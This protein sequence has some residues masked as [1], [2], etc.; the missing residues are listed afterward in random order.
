MGK[1]LKALK[2]AI[3]SIVLIAIC[4]SGCV[5]IPD[6]VQ[7]TVCAVQGT[8]DGVD[9]VYCRDVEGNVYTYTVCDIDMY[10][11]QIGIVYNVTK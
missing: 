5:H 2:Y 4:I 8:D 11:I 1:N 9:T 6:T 10:D 3:I 7:C